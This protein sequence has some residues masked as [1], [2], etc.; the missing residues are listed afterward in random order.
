MFSER[1]PQNKIP[2]R[3]VEGSNLLRSPESFEVYFLQ[4]PVSHEVHLL[5]SPG[6]HEVHPLQSPGSHEVH[7][8]R[9]PVSCGPSIGGLVPSG[10]WVDRAYVGASNVSFQACIGEGARW[11]LDF[12][13]TKC[14]LSVLGLIGLH[15]SRAGVSTFSLLVTGFSCSR[16]F[17][18]LAHTVIPMTMDDWLS[19][20]VLL[21][22][23]WKGPVIPAG[24]NSWLCSRKS[25]KNQGSVCCR[26]NYSACFQYRVKAYRLS[27]L[28]SSI[29]SGTLW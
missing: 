22:A 29:T 17:H 12:S 5:R 13:N 25:N 3:C 11:S 27:F 24:S 28:S 9:S 26:V 7:L 21:E 20:S 8:L 4:S 6:S 19:F 2:V 16:Q 23:A 15:P 10:I 14:P 1:T 18:T